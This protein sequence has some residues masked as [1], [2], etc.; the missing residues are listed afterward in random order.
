MLYFAYGS[1][2]N[3]LQ[4][5][6]RCPRSQPRFRAVLPGYKLIFTG[7]SRQWRGA[8]ASIKPFQG[9][10]VSGAVYEVPDEDLPRLDRAEGYPAIHDRL[11]VRVI[12]EDGATHR[13]ITYIKRD[14]SPGAPSRE[15]MTLIR[16]GYRDWEIE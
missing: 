2:L 6:Q 14:Q 10:K 13:A 5:M 1:N 9:E 16:Q 11:T 7:W 8:T 3:R 15:Y 4:M 12:D